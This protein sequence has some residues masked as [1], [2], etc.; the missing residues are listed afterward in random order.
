MSD[1]Q[2]ASGMIFDDV[3]FLLKVGDQLGVVDLLGQRDGLLDVLVSGFVLVLA[4][5]GLAAQVVE[6]GLVAGYACTES[7][8]SVRR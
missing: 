4:A 3:A 7:G 8:R 1:A 6:G 5:V 2:F